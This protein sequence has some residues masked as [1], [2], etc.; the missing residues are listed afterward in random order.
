M[1]N[2]FQ[3]M[4]NRFRHIGGNVELFPGNVESFPGILEAFPGIHLLFQESF[5][6]IVCAYN[7]PGPTTRTK[8]Q[9]DPSITHDVP[10]R[11]ITNLQFSSLTTGAEG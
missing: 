4:W 10:V 6:G 5:P 8:Y 1:W 9:L 2:R 7:P 11:E 3:E